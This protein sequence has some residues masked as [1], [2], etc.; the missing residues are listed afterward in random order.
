LSS[1]NSQYGIYENIIA[2]TLYSSLSLF[3]W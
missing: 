2:N 3:H 1:L